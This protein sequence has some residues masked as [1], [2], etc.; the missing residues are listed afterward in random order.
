MWMEQGRGRCQAVPKRHP[1]PGG[2]ATKEPRAVPSGLVGLTGLAPWGS[3]VTTGGVGARTIRFCRIARPPP[4]SWKVPFEPGASPARPSGRNTGSLR[5]GQSP[6]RAEAWTGS[7]KYGP[8]GE[9][10]GN[11]FAF[12]GL[13]VRVAL[14]N[15]KL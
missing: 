5:T 4:G 14:D 3:G 9:A 10:P 6:P 13:C 8:A 2:E 11:V 7:K 1:R 15:R 12:A